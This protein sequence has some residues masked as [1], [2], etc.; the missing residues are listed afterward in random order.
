MKH[1]TQ[2]RSL[3]S[4]FRLIPGLFLNNRMELSLC[5]NARS[6][7]LFFIILFFIQQKFFNN[8]KFLFFQWEFRQEGILTVGKFDRRNFDAKKILKEGN[9]DGQGILTALPNIF[10]NFQNINSNSNQSIQALQLK[11]TFSN[12]DIPYTLKKQ[13]IEKKNSFIKNIFPKI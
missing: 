1:E 9:F 4:S 5:F 11:V 3:L 2:Q 10:D 12:I 7:S 13:N 6:Y 8:S